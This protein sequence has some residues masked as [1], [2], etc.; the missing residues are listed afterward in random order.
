TK[1]WVL[2]ASDSEV[3]GD[4]EA[5]LQREDYRGCVSSFDLQTCDD[6]GKRAAQLVISKTGRRS[7]LL[8]RPLPQDAP[9]RRCPDISLTRTEL[10]WVPKA[11]LNNGL[12]RTITYFNRKRNC[13]I[14]VREGPAHVRQRSDA[15]HSL[16]LTSL[17][18]ASSVLG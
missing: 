2:Q 16:C 11:P 14:S 13:K 15:L 17:A 8:C 18:K 10:G 1:A 5:D 7:K 3:F 4:P 12:D 9:R 6:E